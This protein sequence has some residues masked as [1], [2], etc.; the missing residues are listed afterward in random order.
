MTVEQSK[1]RLGFIPANRGFFSA[2]LAAKMR[3]QTI[4][5]M[6]RQGIEVV[7]PGS[8]Q[9]KVGCVEN[10]QEAEICASCSGST[11]CRES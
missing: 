3:G 1:V 4:D 11:A 6:T 10:R 2:E 7:V 5:A 8:E 9:T